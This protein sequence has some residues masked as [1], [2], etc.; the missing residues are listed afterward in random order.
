[1]L[2]PNTLLQNRYLVSRLVE[3]T[4]TGTIYLAEDRERGSEVQLKEVAGG[5]AEIR[6][7][8]ER[9]AESPTQHPALGGVID[10]FTE[11]DNFY[12]VTQQLSDDNLANLIQEK[13]AFPASDVARWGSSLLDALN[14]LHTQE[15]PVIHGHIRPESL[16][17]TSD[18]QIV[19]TNLSQAAAMNRDADD[20]D[21][22][23]SPE[24]TG[25]EMDARSDLYSLGATLYHLLTGKTPPDAQTRLEAVQSKEPD[26]LRGA[27]E[28]NEEVPANVAGVIHRAMSLNRD[29]RY[30][31]AAEMRD[32]LEDASGTAQ[33][34]SIA[35]KRTASQSPAA[36]QSFAESQTSPEKKASTAPWVIGA[37][38][39][40][41]IA[42]IAITLMIVRGRSADSDAKKVKLNSRDMEIIFQE[43]V[44]PQMQASIDKN[45]DQ[46]KMLIKEVKER[47][48]VAQ[49]AEAEGY[50]SKPEVQS[51]IAFANDQILHEEY[52]KKNPG[53][54]ATDDEVNAYHQA[55]PTAF[56]DFVNSNPQLKQQM[57]MQMQ[58]LGPQAEGMKERFKKEFG[59]IKVIADRARNEKLDQD[60][61][62]RVKL[63][64]NRNSALHSAYLNELEKNLGSQIK[65]EDVEPYYQSHQ[66]ELDE[67]K[68]RHIMLTPQSG[69][70]KEEKRT[71]A[72]EVLT[73]ARN[74]ED[75]A[76]L[77]TE[78]S[79]EP[80]SKMNGGD[81][82]F[83]WKGTGLPPEF[84]KAMLALQPG[85]MSDVIETSY[86][87]HIIKVE[88]RRPKPSPATDEK[89]RQEILDVMKR[90]RIQNRVNEIVASS[91]V[92]IAEDFKTTPKP[93]EMPPTGI[94]GHGAPPQ[95]QG[96]Q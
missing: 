47:F 51:G 74:G 80:M 72:A 94:P 64:F 25:G 43:M 57:E 83:V 1:M 65:P 63:L 7:E 87:F 88:E 35:E 76:Q 32:S 46:K 23:A 69:G 8:L 60:E 48:A 96:Q 89:V 15:P 71:R 13:G 2:S 77:A 16:K 75:F 6:R 68:V 79:E 95:P 52:N 81:M 19:L 34:E 27:D 45:P 4:D 9:E 50:A 61:V 49:Q 31:S 84:E 24:Q 92:E 91:S 3:M 62:V 26:L 10:S 44:P 73:R 90:E 29:E 14:H 78:F 22:Y 41:A 58:M 66:S 53:A 86:G 33:F 30:A 11:G 40:L 37:I 18:G 82:G 36:T 21:A 28:V 20:G 17:L 54:S 38:A 67:V 39:V 85:Q 70:T 5:D 59:E 55:N 93:A 42:A 12:V 56:D